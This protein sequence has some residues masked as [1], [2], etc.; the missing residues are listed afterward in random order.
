MR[1]M[2]TIWRVIRAP[3]RPSTLPV[4]QPYVTASRV[5]SA[6]DQS[7][8]PHLWVVL[9]HAGGAWLALNWRRV[10]IGKKAAVFED[11]TFWLF[12]A[13]GLLLG[14]YAQAHQSEQCAVSHGRHLG[15]NR[16]SAG[17]ARAAGSARTPQRA[18]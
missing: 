17:G 16:G 7:G 18:D 9:R 15:R 1:S 4:C 5:I 12:V 11:S 8:R 2:K 6:G 13:P 10:E 14:L 3:K